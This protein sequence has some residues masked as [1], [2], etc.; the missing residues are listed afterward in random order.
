MFKR[1]LM[2]ALALS[3][4]GCPDPLPTSAKSGA[5]ANSK[6][7][8][9]DLYGADKSKSDAAKKK[10]ISQG[11]AGAETVLAV[12]IDKNWNWH[13]KAKPTDGR[14]LQN[15]LTYIKEGSQKAVQE[16]ITDVL[17]GIG[18]PAIPALMKALEYHEYCRQAACFVLTQLD[19]EEVNKALREKLRSNDVRSKASAL[20]A[21][22]VLGQ[23]CRPAL[24]ALYDL[25]SGSDLNYRVASAR[26][27]ALINAEVFNKVSKV[28]VELGKNRKLRGPMLDE[29]LKECSREETEV[30][31][32]LYL[33]L[34]SRKNK[35]EALIAIRSLGP[36]ARPLV[37]LILIHALGPPHSDIYVQALAQST[38]QRLPHEIIVAESINCLRLGSKRL[39]H[40]AARQLALSK[41]PVDSAIPEL[42]KSLPSADPQTAN[43]CI[44]AISKSGDKAKPFIPKLLLANTNRRSF[45]GPFVGL[46]LKVDPDNALKHIFDGLNHSNDIVR[47][48]SAEC[49]KFYP[50]KNAE[51]VEKLIKMLD[52]K[53]PIVVRESIF[54]LGECG[55]LGKKALPKIRSLAA[56]AKKGEKYYEAAVAIAERLKYT[57]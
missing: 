45:S 46:L 50:D 27:I 48:R 44:S 38:L 33:V 7:I 10:L 15:V 34:S 3:L 16:P 54:A 31:A 18:K 57:R 21:I 25:F 19:T 32:S 12:M 28:L 30:A 24:P 5:T 11:A 35:Q 6:P 23:R 37:P 22:G 51:L 39:K 4:A 13:Q 8:I 20:E 53:N 52:D 17:L 55:S 49:L 42:I 2:F 47:Q 56:D 43:L 40:A 26:A 36:K 41:G 1:F 29:K 9:Q 14:R